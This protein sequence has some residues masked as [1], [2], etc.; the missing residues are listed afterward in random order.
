MRLVF[1]LESNGLLDEL[2]RI[3]C[4][5]LTDIDTEQTYSLSPSEVETGVKMLLDA[6]DRLFGGA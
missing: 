4:L 1:D 2:H 6:A 3:H 5:C